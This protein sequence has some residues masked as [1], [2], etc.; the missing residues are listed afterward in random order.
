MTPRAHAGAEAGSSTS[1]ATARPT[2]RR[3]RTSTTSAPATRSRSRCRTRRSRTASGHRVVTANDMSGAP[4]PGT[5]LE[6]Q[7]CHP[8]F[9]ATHRYIV[10][11]RP[12]LGRLRVAGRRTKKN[13]EQQVKLTGAP[14]S[15]DAVRHAGRAPAPRRGMHARSCASPGGSRGSSTTPS[16]LD[17]HARTHELV[18]CFGAWQVHGR[19]SAGQKA[20]LRVA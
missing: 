9:F 6:L 5:R 2:S 10:V 7:A 16:R 14:A 12:R 1:P 8:R 4:S 18:A 11:R 17:A 3:S 20:R 19:A 13:L 15:H